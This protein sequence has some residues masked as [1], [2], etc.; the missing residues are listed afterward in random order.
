M[1]AMLWLVVAL[2]FA[3][4]ALLALVGYAACAVGGASDVRMD[5]GDY[6]DEARHDVP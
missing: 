4:A 5:D 6:A 3:L 2:V 1:S